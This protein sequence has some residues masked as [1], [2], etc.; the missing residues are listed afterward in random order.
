ME[1]G[2]AV[3]PR[4][5]VTHRPAV[6]KLWVNGRANED[7]D[8]W[9]EEVRAQCERC[10]DDK[11]ETPEVQAER[12][13]R[14][15]IRGD[16]R[17]STQGRRVTITVGEVLRARGDVLRNKANGPGSVY[18]QRTRWRIGSTS[19]LKENVVHQRRGKFTALFLK[20]PDARLEKGLRGFRAILLSVFSEWYTAVLVDLLHEE[21]EWRKLHVGAER[22]VNCEHM[23]TLVTNIFQ[24]HWEWQEDKRADLQPGMYRYNTAFMASLDVKTAFDVAKP[25]VVSKILTLTRVHGHLTAACRNARYSRLR[26]FREQLDGL[27]VLSVHRPRRCA[28]TCVVGACGQVCAVES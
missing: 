18:R 14:Q 16:R 21:K 6:T 3:L 11:T 8:E 15:R 9:T 19:G 27:S 1:A 10:Y 22:G 26:E 7:R 17:V 4:V 5:K 24:R 28:S 20:K 13:R 23:Q 12:F 2:R 25:S